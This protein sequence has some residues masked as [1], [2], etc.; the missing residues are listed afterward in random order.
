MCKQMDIC[1][2]IVRPSNGH[3]ILGGLGLSLHSSDDWA[4]ETPSQPLG[5]LGIKHYIHKNSLFQV[6]LGDSAQ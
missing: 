6:Q 4:A 5:E 1:K 3:N 2:S